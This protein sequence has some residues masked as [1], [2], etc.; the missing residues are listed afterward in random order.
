MRSKHWQ[1]R[2]LVISPRPNTIYYPCGKDIFVLNTKAQESCLLFTLKFEPRCIAASGEWLCCGG[3]NG[4]Y[5]AVCFTVKS[6]PEILL[7]RQTEFDA[8]ISAT[9]NSSRRTDQ[10]QRKY[11]VLRPV[12]EI[13][14]TIGIDIVN[15]V[16]I[17][18]PPD[19]SS[20]WTYQEPVVVVSNNDRNVSILK[21]RDAVILDTLTLPD[22]V[23]RSLISPDGNLLVSICDD[24]FLYIHRRKK[25]SR[26]TKNRLNSNWSLEGKV[27]LEAQACTDIPET[28]GSFAAAFSPSG[29]YLAV[30]THKGI[31]SVFDTKNIYASPVKIFSSKSNSSREN[32]VRTMEF[33]TGPYDLLAWTE[34][35]GRVGVADVR[36]LFLS[37]QMLILDPNHDAVERFFV[38][39]RVDPGRRRE[40]SPPNRQ[41]NHPWIQTSLDELGRANDRPTIRGALEVPQYTRLETDI[42]RTHQSDAQQLEDPIHYETSEFMFRA[43]SSPQSLLA[44]LNTTDGAHTNLVTIREVASQDRTSHTRSLVSETTRE[45]HRQS[46]QIQ[47]IETERSSARTQVQATALAPAE[48]EIIAYPAIPQNENFPTRSLERLSLSPSPSQDSS[49]DYL[50]LESE[51]LDRPNI[52]NASRSPL[53]LAGLEQNNFEHRLRRSSRGLLYMTVSESQIPATN[54]RYE[55]QIRENGNARCSMMGCCWSQDGKI[56][57]AGTED[58]IHEFHVNI[59]SRKRFPSIVFY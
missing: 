25:S 22:C 18:L 24:P 44:S 7:G 54:P 41:I 59:Q 55:T 56:L 17:W 40:G 42:L 49:I 13:T 8:Q 48:M 19:L 26:M 27:R 4:E 5:A 14:R 12:V 9:T 30:A 29:K 10:L 11:E 15:C 46:E 3:D 34:S 1:L 36:N 52:Y 47:A 35:K 21:L 53:E 45:S 16:T 32:Y 38:E 6:Q 51:P 20:E 23:N 39:N 33:S 43:S 37:R 57:Y 2:S 31:I 28:T 50:L 58:G